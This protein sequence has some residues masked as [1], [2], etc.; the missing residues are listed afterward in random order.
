M[1]VFNLRIMFFLLFILEISVSANISSINTIKEITSINYSLKSSFYLKGYYSSY[2]GGEGYFIWDKTMDKINAN[3]GTIIDPSQKIDKQGYGKGKGCWIRKYSG[4]IKT[5][6]FG[7]KTDGSD[8]T[9]QFNNL[10]KYIKYIKGGTV[11]L[12]SKR[13]STKNLDF[14]ACSNLTILGQ[15][16]NSIIDIKYTLNGIGMNFG[17]KKGIG[18]TQN[19]YLSNF[20]ITHSGKNKIDSLLEFK[21][22]PTKRRPSETSGFITLKNI[23]LKRGAK[24]AL[25]LVGVS[26]VYGENIQTEYNTRINYGLYISQDININTGVYTFVNCSFRAQET[27]LVIE[28]SK[29]LIDSILFQGCGFFNYYNPLAKEVIILNG[30]NFP[31]ESVK[32][33]ASHIE[34]RNSS[35]E[36]KVAISLMG[37]LQTIS[38]DTIHLSCGNSNTKKQADYVFKLH[39]KGL[40]KAITFS[41]IS[42][43]RCK[44]RKFKGYI[45]YIEGL[46]KFD[47]KYPIKIEELV[48]SVT[49]P[50]FLKVDIAKNIQ[51]IQKN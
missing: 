34:S 30:K 47:K 17:S 8:A 28:S 26:H 33:L 24:K 9:H 12:P 48:T 13:I 40:Y 21:S 38:F 29:Q 45:Y 35:K 39:G 23:F 37:K 51:Y 46:S 25:S 14:T 31:I 43:L 27:A 3:G 15:G 32:F 10:I 2:D 42:I 22:G 36:E 41:N 18:G 6:W 7:I 11:I 19:I 16:K 5:E 4:Y 44:D 50:F 49:N 1:K 20:T